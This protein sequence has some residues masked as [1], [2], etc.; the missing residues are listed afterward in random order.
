MDYET[1]KL[2]ADYILKGRD[3]GLMYDQIE[4]DNSRDVHDIAYLMS[5]QNSLLY[6]GKYIVEKEYEPGKI[7]FV[8]KAMKEKLKKTD[9][10]LVCFSCDE[11]ISEM[12]DSRLKNFAHRNSKRVVFLKIKK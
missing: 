1:T 12:I 3:L 2:A 5:K 9:I 6:T 8:L 10:Y 7:L 4:I 11:E